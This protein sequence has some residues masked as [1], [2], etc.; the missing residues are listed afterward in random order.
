[1]RMRAKTRNSVGITDIVQERTIVVPIG[2]E[3]SVVG[4]KIATAVRL[5]CS[6]GAT[7]VQQYLNDV[8]I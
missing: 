8:E 4:K 3:T 5:W 7:V 1:M 2:V 6:G